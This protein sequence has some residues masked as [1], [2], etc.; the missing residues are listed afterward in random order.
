MSQNNPR[1]LPAL[2]FQ[3]GI[4]VG[5]LAPKV[6]NTGHH[7]PLSIAFDS[8]C[9]I[10]QNRDSLGFQRITDRL[11]QP[12]MAT[13]TECVANGKIVVAEDCKNAQGCFEVLEEFCRCLNVAVALVDEVTRERDQVRLLIQRAFENALE[14]SEWYLVPAMKI[15]ELRNPKAVKGVR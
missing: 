15:G 3:G 1:C 4:W 6:V 7:E 9:L 14:V 12:T 13:E 10:P 2:F 8:D 5:F 11:M